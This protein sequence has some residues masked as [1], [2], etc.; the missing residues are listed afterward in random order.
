MYIHIFL[1]KS[2]K[3]TFITSYKIYLLEFYENSTSSP[4]SSINYIT[5][6][7][8]F[9]HLFY[10]TLKFSEIEKYNRFFGST[11][12][13]PKSNSHSF[14][15]PITEGVFNHSPP[16]NFNLKPTQLLTLP[17]PWYK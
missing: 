16:L 12:F 6:P 15:H 7:N 10:T 14:S 17:P 11:N 1:N 9:T 5:L 2:T 4:T 3:L 8:N 13:C